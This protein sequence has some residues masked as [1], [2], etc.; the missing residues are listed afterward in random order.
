MANP[1]MTPQLHRWKLT[2]R[3]AGALGLAELV[4][5]ER[6]HRLAFAPAAIPPATLGALRRRGMA[7]CG[8][9]LAGRTVT[10]LTDQ[11]CVARGYLEQLE[12]AWPGVLQRWKEN[13]S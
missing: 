7:A 13:A 6:A 11:G 2:P 9:Q 4:R 5:V 10:L 12:L 1:V 8:V 3:L